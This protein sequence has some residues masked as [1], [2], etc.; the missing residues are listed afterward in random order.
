MVAEKDI[1]VDEITLG[2]KDMLKKKKKNKASNS[3]KMAIKWTGALPSSEHS[4]IVAV[5][6]H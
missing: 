6:A 5:C 3:A 4:S 2:M 1:A